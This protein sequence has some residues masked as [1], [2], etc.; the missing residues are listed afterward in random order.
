MT[1]THKFLILLCTIALMTT[2]VSAQDATE[3]KT[4]KKNSKA[5]M[6]V[7]LESASAKEIAWL[8]YDSGLA[9]AK[10]ESK[11]V[12]I[13]FFTTWCGWCKKMDATTFRDSAVVAAFNKNFIGVRV[14]GDATSSFLT[15]EGE[16]M[17]E[18]SFTQAVGVRGFPTY[19]FLDSE[20]KGVRGVSG[21]MSA[22]V[23]M[24]NLKWVAGR[25]YKTMS[26]D[27]YVKKEN[28]KG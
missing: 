26:Y 15:R 16:R 23:F 19:W 3:K 4:S 25:H 2:V 18:R 1:R 9:K 11:A 10:A 8:S 12:V 5:A 6:A 7:S 27:N 13:D 22:E 21:Y 20:G 24:S 14:N 17:S 28:G